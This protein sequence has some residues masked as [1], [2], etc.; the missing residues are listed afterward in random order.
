MAMLA[1]MP[2]ETWAQFVTQL[3]LSV[4]LV[5]FFVWTGNE[6]KK[7]LNG[8]LSKLEDLIHSSLRLA[9]DE[10]T[11]A[12]TRNTEA[13]VRVERAIECSM[14]ETGRDKGRVA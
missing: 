4:A 8:R 10:S 1:E 12:I 7:A 2:V 14:G 13:L 3:G 5:L 11:K 6:E 9:L